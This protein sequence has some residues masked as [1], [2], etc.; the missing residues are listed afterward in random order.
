VLL[1]AAREKAQAEDITISQYV[2]R[3]LMRWV[4]TLPTDDSIE[5]EKTE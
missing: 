3:C 2:R 5:K 1:D 4:G